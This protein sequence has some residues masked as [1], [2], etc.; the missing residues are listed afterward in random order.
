M[1]KKSRKIPK[2]ITALKISEK[3]MEIYERH[4]RVAASGVS[5]ME[6][7]YQISKQIDPDLREAVDLQQRQWLAEKEK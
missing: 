2:E 1:P 4:Q 6:V 7:I 5:P 3:K